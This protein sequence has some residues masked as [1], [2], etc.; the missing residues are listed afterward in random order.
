M[1]SMRCLR[2][3]E[4]TPLPLANNGFGEF[5]QASGSV[6]FPLRAGLVSRAEDPL[7]K[8]SPLPRGR[9]DECDGLRSHA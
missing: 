9:S 4:G 8:L 6:E 7:G 5:E 1:P 2:A 3:V